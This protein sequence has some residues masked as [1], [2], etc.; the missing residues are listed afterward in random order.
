MSLRF[1]FRESYSVT[2]PNDWLHEHKLMVQLV[3]HQLTRAK[4][5]QKQQADKHRSEHTFEW[6]IG[7]T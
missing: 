7:S 6:V 5:R 2:S 1:V 4:Q 3:Q